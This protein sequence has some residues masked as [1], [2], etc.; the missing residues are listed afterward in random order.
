MVTPVFVHIGA[1]DLFE[2][3]W[4]TLEPKWKKESRGFHLDPHTDLEL[5]DKNYCLIT[6]PPPPEPDNVAIASFFFVKSGKKGDRKFK[7]GTTPVYVCMTHEVYDRWQDYCNQVE[8]GGQDKFVTQVV[9]Y[10]S[11]A[12][13]NSSSSHPSHDVLQPH[14]IT[15][16][17]AGRPKKTV[18]RLHLNFLQCMIL[19]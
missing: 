15:S 2:A 13:A 4:Q 18:R 8:Y 5:Y 7:T 11:V 19:M 14:S 6:P 12:I 17:K 9:S 10:G 16:S 3:L 1:I